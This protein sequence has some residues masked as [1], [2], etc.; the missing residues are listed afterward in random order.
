MDGRTSPDLHPE[1]NAKNFFYAHV[2]NLSTGVI[3]YGFFMT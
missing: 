1:T 2:I 3:S